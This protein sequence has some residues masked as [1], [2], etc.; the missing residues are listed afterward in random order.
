MALSNYTFSII[1]KPGKNNQDTDALSR[2]KWPEIIE[3]NSQTVTACCEG[4]Q[5]SHGKAEILCHSAQTLGN[6]F[7][8]NIQPGIIQVDWSQTK[9]KDP[10]GPKANPRSNS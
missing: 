5:A 8:N 2:I 1:Y 9:Y 3:M 6:L 10:M 4:G 7:R